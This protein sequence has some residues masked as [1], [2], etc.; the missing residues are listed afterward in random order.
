[1]HR[2]LRGVPS[3]GRLLALAA[4]LVTALALLPLPGASAQEG[5]DVTPAR[6]EGE[7][8]VHTA[9]NIATLT[10]QQADVAHIAF[11]GAFPDA[12]TASFAAGSVDGPILLSPFEAVPEPTLDALEELDVQRVVLVGGPLALSEDVE[13]QLRDAGYEVDRISGADRY[14]TAVAVAVHYGTEVG[15][16][17]IDGER[18]AVVASGEVFADALSVGPIA[19]ALGLPLL[20]TPPTSTPDAVDDALAQLGIERIVVIGGTAAVSSDVVNAFQDAGYEVERWGGETRTDT[21]RVVADQ[22]LARFGFTAD[23]VLLARGDNFPDALAASIHGAVQRAPLLLTAT[24]RTLSQFTIGWLRAACPHVDAIRALGGSAAVTT[25]ALA[26]AV[27]EAESCGDQAHTEQTYLITPQEPVT[28]EP[29]DVHDVGVVFGDGDPTPIDFAL[30]PCANADPVNPP[31]T[32]ADEDGDGHAD[33]IG[34]TDTGAALI[35]SVNGVPTSARHLTGLAPGASG[36]I[37]FELESPD[38][39]CSVPTAFHDANG[40]N[41]LDVDAEGRPLEAFGYGLH[42]WAD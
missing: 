10:F 26:E 28:L 5:P 3:A 23:L 13:E 24:P 27:D 32:F 9:A 8:R 41:E 22:A 19:A 35:T 1:M 2:T 40:N 30:F 15:V 33:G 29:G 21:A 7:T 20:L 25:Q 12:L 34:T 17:E 38:P 31:H 6:V 42:A 37:E 16:G 11:S 18:A 39:D 14:A 4:A 36:V